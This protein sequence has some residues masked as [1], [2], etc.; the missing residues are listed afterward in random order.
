[1]ENNNTTG[2]GSF[3]SVENTKIKEQEDAKRLVQTAREVWIRRLIDHSRNN[4]LLFYRDLKVGTLD[5]TETPAA[6]HRLLEGRSLE[7]KDLLPPSGKQLAPTEASSQQEVDLSR[8]EA[9][10]KVQ[11]SLLA[12]QR[13]ASSNLEEKGIETLFLALGMATWPA[14]DGGRP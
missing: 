13:K 12:I 2:S 10:K 7:V 1:M 3:S 14:A 9:R 5:L 4:P 6:L 11:H 8:E